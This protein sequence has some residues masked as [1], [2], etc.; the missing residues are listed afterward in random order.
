MAS[1]GRPTR[2]EFDH[3]TYPTGDID[4]YRRV[5]RETVVDTDQ[6]VD[7]SASVWIAWVKVRESQIA[8]KGLFAARDFAANETIG[9]YTGFIIGKAS[10]SDKDPVEILVKKLGAYPEG[11][12]ITNVNGYYID[13]RLPMQSNAE[14][15][16]LIR[17]PR[18]FM[19]Q[20]N[21][22]WPGAHVHIAND[23][24]GTKHEPNVQLTRG[25]YLETLRPVKSGEELMWAYGEKYWEDA[26]TLGTEENPILM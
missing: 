25:G 11:D 20:P 21:W 15:A 18:A 5:L 13:A 3:F 2:M 19:P 23:P 16:S 14:Q 7:Q 24:R 22:G 1:P 8:G 12:A 4:V 6:S 17:R 26:D 9:R 10:S